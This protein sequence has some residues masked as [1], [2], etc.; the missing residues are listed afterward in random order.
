MSYANTWRTV[1]NPSVAAKTKLPSPHVG[2]TITDGEMPAS[3]RKITT[4]SAS[5]R[6]VWKSPY[7]ILL[8]TFAIF[9]L[10]AEHHQLCPPPQS[11]GS[12]EVATEVH[13]KLSDNQ[14]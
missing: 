14:L 7:S 2:S 5:S 1:G 10:C 11:L 4:A 13:L 8:F 6:G 9:T 3:R 12:T